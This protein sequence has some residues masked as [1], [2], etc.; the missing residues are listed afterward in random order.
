[1]S[2]SQEHQHNPGSHGRYSSVKVLIAYGTSEPDASKVTGIDIEL[3][4]SSGYVL[5][6]GLIICN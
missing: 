6:L 1:M 4:L 2:P 5:L 3:E